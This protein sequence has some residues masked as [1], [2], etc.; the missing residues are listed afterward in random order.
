ML[1]LDVP[2]CR[3]IIHADGRATAEQQG[4]CAENSSAASPHSI[5][6][7]YRMGETT[8]GTKSSHDLLLNYRV[9]IYN[10]V[11]LSTSSSTLSS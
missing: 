8:S 4:S 5:I 9:I 7:E 10:I 11:L 3:I 2:V 1:I 6:N